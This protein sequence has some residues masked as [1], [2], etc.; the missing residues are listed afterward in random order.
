[1]KYSVKLIKNE[2]YQIKLFA[3]TKEEQDI[4]NKSSSEILETYF[5]EAVRKELGNSANLL[6]I[7]DDRL[8]PN[9]IVGKVVKAIGIGGF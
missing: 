4:L 8:L 7:I 6:S 3:E 9:S 5:H 2:I 1:M